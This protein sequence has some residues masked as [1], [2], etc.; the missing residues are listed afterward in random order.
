MLKHLTNSTQILT[1]NAYNS[2]AG[3][4]QGEKMNAAST[5][6]PGNPLPPPFFILSPVET[7][8]KCRESLPSIFLR[9]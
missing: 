2:L 6:G 1:F 9:K 4:T 8:S 3:G 7:R 5:S